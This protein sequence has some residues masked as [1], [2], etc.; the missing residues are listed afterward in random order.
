M[1]FRSRSGAVRAV[2]AAVGANPISII[3][4]CHRVLGGNGSLTGYSGG[5]SRKAALLHMKGW[6]M[7]NFV[8]D[9]LPRHLRPLPPGGQTKKF[10]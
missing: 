6:A 10:D 4:P 5:L 7:E 8:N 3:V 9:E 2:G 1:L